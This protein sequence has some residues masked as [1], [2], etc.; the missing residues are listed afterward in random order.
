[1]ARDLAPSEPNEFIQLVDPRTGRLT[2]DGID[3]LTETWRQIVAGFA[4]VPCTASG[5]NAI[6]LSPKLHQEG[7]ETYGDAMAFAFE[8]ANT[9]TGSVTIQLGE[10]TAV[11]AYLTNGSVQA[12]SGD[13][14]D[15]RIYLAIYWSSL[16]SGNGG[17]VL[18]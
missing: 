10:L 2:P 9:S 16:N 5:T 14:V 18:W 13:V 11:N 15:G 12:G 3:L 17:F 8:A 7:K 6:T 4:V 1:V